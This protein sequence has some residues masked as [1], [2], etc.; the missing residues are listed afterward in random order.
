LGTYTSKTA[1]KGIYIYNFDVKTGETTLSSTQESKDPSF[2][3]RNN[4]FIYA[5]NEVPNQEGLFLPILLGRSFSIS[6]P[7][8]GE[9]PCFVEVHLRVPCSL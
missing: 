9:S 4:N 3:A 2:L 5:V 1:S 8:G 6:L 7:S